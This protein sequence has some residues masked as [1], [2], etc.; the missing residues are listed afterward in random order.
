MAGSGSARNALT[1]AGW[2]TYA[3]RSRRRFSGRSRNCTSFV[4][5]ERVPNPG[6]ARRVAP[7]RKEVGATGALS[8]LQRDLELRR[9]RQTVVGRPRRIHSG[10]FSSNALG[11]LEQL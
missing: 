3:R 2:G 5:A 7:P 1:I 6:R 4:L 8:R 9:E 11:R 10:G